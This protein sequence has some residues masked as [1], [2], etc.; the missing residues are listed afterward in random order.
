MGQTNILISKLTAILF[1]L[2]FNS[3][4]AQKTFTDS[5]GLNCSYAN[6]A[7][8]VYLTPI[9]IPANVATNASGNMSIKFKYAGDLD[10]YNEDLDLR[11]ENNT[12]IGQCDVAPNCGSTFS[13]KTFTLPISTFGS[14]INDNQLIFSATSEYGINNQCSFNGNSSINF[15]TEVVVSINYFE[16]A[17]DAGIAGFISPVSQITTGTSPIIISGTNFGT[18]A[19]NSVNVGW[20]VNGIN[21]TAKALTFSTP[22]SSGST[23][24]D[25]LANYNF[26]GATHF[27]LKSWTNSPNGNSDSLTLNDTT[28]QSTC[29]G[30]NGTYTVGVSGANYSSLT[31]AYD[32]LKNCGMNGPVTLSLISNITERVHLQDSI[33]GLTAS[34]KL[35]IQGSGYTLQYDGNSTNREVISLDGINHLV[36]DSLKIKTLD[37]YYGTGIW[38]HNQSDSNEVKNCY[39]DLTSTSYT[40][41]YYSSGILISGTNNGINN[42]YNGS[43]NLISSNTFDGGYYGMLLTGYNTIGLGNITNVIEGNK[44]ID[45]YRYGIYNRYSDLNVIRGNEFS[46]PTRS[47]NNY[48]GIYSNY[49]KGFEI[50]AN[51]FM[52][53]D[54]SSNTTDQYL[55]YNNNC[56]AT[57]ADPN[58][59]FNNVVYDVISGDVLYFIYDYY[60]QYQEVYNNTVFYKN[61]T[62]T[63]QAIYGI[64]NRYNYYTNYKNNNFYFDVETN[65]QVF[66]FY[67]YS[68]SS[69]ILSDNNNI[70]IKDATNKGNQYFGYASGYRK[71]LSDFQLYY[72]RETNGFES[73]PL[74]VS[75][76]TLIPQNVA[77]N[78]TGDSTVNITYDVLGVQRGN[79]PDVGAYEFT[80]TNYDLALTQINLP[81]SGC[82]LNVANISGTVENFGV[83]TYSSFTA[84]FK[85]G[86]AAVQTQIF[87]SAIAS[88]SSFN[89]TFDSLAYFPTAGQTYNV[90]V[91]ITA[92]NDTK[93]SN[94]SILNQQVKNISPILLSTNDSLF[95]PVSS[96]SYPIY[97]NFANGWIGNPNAA[98]G[99][100]WTTDNAFSQ[101]NTGP[102]YDHTYGNTSGRYFYTETYSYVDDQ[103]ATLTS[104][105]IELSDTSS[106]I[107]FLN[108]WYHKYGSTMG[109]LFIQIGNGDTFTTIDSIMGQTHTA[110]SN[111]GAPWLLKFIDLS[112]YA[113]Q[114]FNVRFKAVSDYGVYGDMALDD[115]KIIFQPLTCDSISTVTIS[116]ITDTSADLSWNNNNGSTNTQIQYGLTGFGIGSGTIDST[117]GSFY[118]ISGLSNL[119]NYEVYIRNKCSNGNFT[120]WSGPHAIFTNSYCKTNLHSTGCGTASG[121]NS[122]QLESIQNLNTGCTGITNDN[123]SFYPNQITDITEDESYTIT[124]T[125]GGTYRTYFGVWMDFNKDGLFNSTNEYIGSLY[126]SNSSVPNSYT[127]TVPSGIDTGITMMRVRSDYYNVSSNESCSNMTYGETEDYLVNLLPSPTCPKPKNLGAGFNSLTSSRLFWHAKGLGSQWEVEYGSSNFTFGTG[128]Q[129]TLT[130][131]TT[132]LNNLGAYS[133]YDYYVRSICGAADTSLWT[134]P[135]NFNTFPYCNGQQIFFGNCAT[136]PSYDIGHV[137]LNT[138]SSTTTN[139][140]FYSYGNFIS[141]STDLVPS[142][143]YQITLNT[144][145]ASPTYFGVWV[146]FN[147]DGD[148]D[149]TNEFA[150]NSTSSSTSIQSGLISVPLTAIQGN[151]LMRVRSSNNQIYSNYSCTNFSFG[152]TEDYTINILA[153]PSC[154]APYNLY[155]YGL[156]TSGASIAWSQQ[157]SGSKW[158]VQYDSVGFTLGTGNSDTTLN[159]NYTIGGLK[160]LSSYDV[161]V[162]EV[163]SSTDSSS[164]VGPFNFITNP[165]CTSN[166]NYS[167]CN[168]EIDTVKFGALN[169]YDQ[170]EPCP[171]NSYHTMFS[172]PSDLAK[173]S[174]FEL[175]VRIKSTSYASTGIWIDWNGDGDFT[176]TDEWIG[177]GVRTYGSL[178]STNI[179]IPI[180]A[181]SGKTLMRVRTRNGT[182]YNSYSCNNLGNGETMDFLLDI[183]EP[184]GCVPP[185]EL[186]A[187]FN[188]FTSSNIS[189]GNYSNAPLFEIEYDTT[190]YTFGTGTTLYSTDSTELISGLAQNG[191]YDYY[192]RAIC[193]TADTSAW[194]S[195]F[196]FTT[197]PYCSGNTTTL[198]YYN[199]SYQCYYKLKEFGIDTFYKDFSGSACPNYSYNL[200]SNVIQIEA[201]SNIPLTLGSS[202]AYTTGTNAAIGVWIDYNQDGDFEDANEFVGSATRYVAK[203]YSINI[204]IP[205][206]ANTGTTIMRVRTSNNTAIYNYMSCY[207]NVYGETKDFVIDVLPAPTCP[208][209]YNLTVN[210]FTTNAARIGFSSTGNGSAWEVKYG[211]TGFNPDSTGTST[212]WY[213]TNDSIKG[214]SSFTSYDVYVKEICSS[215]DS[216][217]W[218]NSVSF[219]TNPYCII[220]QHY[221]GCTSY[222]ID[223]VTYNGNS[224]GG[225]GCSGDAT[226]YSFYDR[227]AIDTLKAGNSHSLILYFSNQYKYTVAWID[228]NKN[229]VFDNTEYYYLVYQY[230]GNATLNFT[231]PEEFYGDLMIRL[232]TSTSYLNTNSACT[233]YNYG[234]SEDYLFAVDPID[235]PKL[236]NFTKSDITDSS[237]TISWSQIDSN[238]VYNFRIAEIGGSLDT[239]IYASNK[240]YTFSNLTSATAYYIWAQNNCSAIGDSLSKWTDSLQVTTLCSPFTAEYHENFNSYE[241]ING[242]HQPVCWTKDDHTASFNNNFY[243]GTD[244]LGVNNDNYYFAQRSNSSS[245]FNVYLISPKFSDFDYGKK[246]ISFFAKSG[247]N[248][249]TSIV[250]GTTNNDTISSGN[251]APLQQFITDGSYQKFTYILDNATS[252]DNRIAFRFIQD[253]N[254]IVYFDEFHYEAP[255][256]CTEPINLSA[257]QVA[258]SSA[259]LTWDTITSPNSFLVSYGIH[260]NS[261]PVGDSGTL[262][263]SSNLTSSLSNLNS[264]TTYW[265]MV[266]SICGSDS[267]AWGGPSYFTTTC[268]PQAAPVLYNFN[269]YPN[270]PTCWSFKGS[271]YYWTNDYYSTP[272]SGTGP[273]Y[274]G[275]NNYGPNYQYLYVENGLS[276]RGDSAVFIMQPVKLNSLTHPYFTFDYHAYG[277]NSGILEIFGTI[278]NGATW[279]KLGEYNKQYQSS[280]TRYFTEHAIDLMQFSGQTITLKFKATRV[281]NGVLGDIA[282]DQLNFKEAPSCRSPQNIRLVSNYKYNQA[283]VEWDTVQGVSSYRLNYT[284]L[285]FGTP[286]GTNSGTISTNNYNYTI[287]GVNQSRDF[288][289]QSVC[290][291]TYSTPEGPYRFTNTYVTY[292]TPYTQDFSTSYPT[293]WLFDSRS[294]SDW[295]YGTYSNGPTA[296]SGP[297]YLH[298]KDEELVEDS[299]LTAISPSLK[300]NNLTNPI[301]EFQLN[302]KNNHV[303]LKVFVEDKNGKHLAKSIRKTTGSNW[304]KQIIPLSSYGD[305]VRIFFVADERSEF[306]DNNL[307]IDLVKIKSSITNDLQT[308]SLYAASNGCGSTSGSFTFQVCNNGS[309]SQSNV[310]V[311]LKIGNTTYS[312]SVSLSAYNCSNVTF[313]NISITSLSGNVALKAYAGLSG[314]GNTGNDTTTSSFYIPNTPQN[315]VVLGD[316]ICNSGDVATLTVSGAA[317]YTWRRNGAFVSNNSTLNVSNLTGTRM[318]TVSGNNNTVSYCGPTNISA[319]LP[320]WTQN[321]G[322]VFDAY[323]DFILDSVE[324]YVRYSG[325]TLNFVLQNA[326][327]TTIST[328]SVTPTTSSGYEKFAVNI[329]VPKGNDLKIINTNNQVAN[330]TPNASQNQAYPFNDDAGVMQLK[331]YSNSSNYVGGIFNW[332]ISTQSCESKTDSVYAHFATIQAPTVS[333]GGT[334]CLNETIP[335]LTATGDS[336]STYWFLASDLNTPLEIGNLFNPASS[337]IGSN[338][339]KVQQKIGT[340]FSSYASATINVLVNPVASVNVDTSICKGQAVRLYAGGGSTYSWSNGSKLTSQLVAPQTTTTYS[341]VVNNTNNC[342]PDTAYVTVT[343]NDI[344]TITISGDQSVCIGDAGIIIANSSAAFTWNNSLGNNDTISVSPSGYT[345]YTAIAID[346]IGCSSS[347]TH[348]VTT[349]SLPNV[350]AG[351]SAFICNGDTTSLYATGASN[352]VWN[353]GDSSQSIEVTP[354]ANTLYTVNATDANGCSNSDTVSV[355]L[356]SN[357]AIASRNDTSVAPGTVIS[358]NPV[359]SGGSGNYSY[360]WTPDSLLA[361]ATTLNNTT[362]AL[363][364]SSVFSF[365]VDDLSNGC[366]AFDL[367]AINIVGGTL[368]GNPSSNINTICNGDSILLLAN[369]GGGTGT[370]TYNWSPGYLFNDSTL[371]NPVAYPTQN[372]VLDVAISDSQQTINEQISVVAKGLPFAN[373]GIDTA[374]CLGASVTLRATGGV[375][376][377]WGLYQYKDS[378]RV[379]PVYPTSYTVTV[380]ANNGCKKTDDVYVSIKSLPTASIIGLSKICIGD[381]TQLT[382]SGGI[383]YAWSSGGNQV[384]EKVSASAT[385]IFTVTATAVNGCSNSSTHTISL[386][387]LPKVDAGQ[388]VGICFGDSDTLTATGALNYSWSN[389]QNIQSIVVTP[390]ATEEYK[391]FGTDANGCTNI[392]SVMVIINQLPSVTAGSDT[393]ICI[394]DT[395]Q[396]SSSEGAYYFWSNGNQT[397]INTVSPTSTSDYIVTVVN[398]SGCYNYDTIQVVVN[399]LPTAYAGVDDTLCLNQ[400]LTL[401]ATGGTTYSWNSGSITAA[402]SVSPVADS[403]FVVTVTDANSCS[404]IDSVEIFINPLPSPSAGADEEICLGLSTTLSASGGTSY[405]WSNNISVKDNTVSNTTNTT[406]TVTVTDDNNCSASDQVLVSVNS[407]PIVVASNDTTVCN[408]TP[409]GIVASGASSYLWNNSDT[410][411]TLLVTPINTTNYIVTGTDSNS[412]ENIDTVKVWVNQNPFAVASNDTVMCIEDTITISASGATYYFW[413]NGGSAST[414]EVSPSSNAQYIVTVVDAHGCFNIDSVNVVVNALPQVFT[415]ANDTIC[416]NSSAFLAGNGATSYSWSNGGI[417][418]NTT[419]SPTAATTYYVVG[420]DNNSC[421][422]I[423]S[424][425]INLFQLPIAD[426]GVDTSVCA[427][428]NALLLATGGVT[429]YSWSSGYSSNSIAV[430]PTSTTNYIVTVTDQNGCQDTDSVLVEFMPLPNV[431][432]S[433]D[434]FTCWGSPVQV[435]VSGGATYVWSTNDITDSIT[436]GPSVNTYYNVVGTDTN[437][438]S[439][440]DSVLVSVNVL[441]AVSTSIDTSIC[442]G[443]TATLFAYGGDY[444]FWNNGGSSSINKVS[445]TATSD[446]IVTIVNTQGCYDYDTVTVVVNSNPIA[447][448]GVDTT[449]CW[450]ESA[451][452]TATGGNSYQWNT[453]NLNNQI[454]VSPDST[455]MYSII[456]TDANTC[457]DV[458]SVIV[459]VNSL[460]NVSAGVDQVICS[461][462]TANLNA[463]GNGLF[464]WSNNDSIAT[465]QLVVTDTTNYM[466]TLIDSNSCSSSDTLTVFT[467][468]LPSA[469]ASLDTSVCLGDSATISASGGTFYFWNNG[470][471]SSTIKVGPLNT[472][473]FIVTVVDTNN[474]FNVDTTTI[475][476]LQLPAA[477]AGVNDTI[478]IGT[479][480]TLTAIGGISYVWSTGAQTASIFSN[481]SVSESYSV[482]VTDANTCQNSDFVYV[483]VNTLPVVDAG[484]NDTIC[485]GNS[486]TLIG[487][488]ANTYQWSGGIFGAQQVV[489][490]TVSNKFS[491]MGTDIN[492]CVNYDSMMVYVNALPLANA[493]VDTFACNGYPVTLNATGGI[494]Y[495]WSNGIQTALN[496][497]SLM[498][499]TTYFVTVTD[500]NGCV[501]SDTI[502]VAINSLPTASGGL[503]QTVCQGDSATFTANGGLYYFWDNGNSGNPMK[504]VPSFTGTYMVTVVDNNGCFDTDSVNV[505][506]NQLPSVSLGTFSKTCDNSTLVTL[507]GGIPTGGTYSS[508]FVNNGQFNPTTSGTGS[509]NIFYAYTNAQGCTDSIGQ[510][511]TVAPAPT[512]TL[513]P[514]ND[515][516]INSG[517]LALGGGIP[518]GGIYSGSNVSAGMFHPNIAGVGITTITYSYTNA[519]GCSNSTS[520]DLNVNDVPHPD[521][522]KDTTVC[523]NIP[524]DL[525]PG[526]YT[527]YLWSTGATIPTIIANTAGNVAV[528]VTDANTCSNSDDI[529]IVVDKCPSVSEL[530]GEGF[531]ISYY[532]N[533]ASDLVN[534]EISGRDLKDVDIQITN[535]NGSVVYQNNISNINHGIAIPID[536]TGISQGVYFIRLQTQKGTRVDC[537]TVN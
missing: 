345:N 427:G 270:I 188:S 285:G 294:G 37:Y 12:Y 433:V 252:G 464:V 293:S 282:V 310:P 187:N 83:N 479:Q 100:F 461:N 407:L 263:T 508:P 197:F 425:T 456:V 486:T 526:T 489:S 435:Y 168:T 146:D 447:N 349:L 275:G 147:N 265:F 498:V 469:I 232:R 191:Y 500:L 326:Q 286:S 90:D 124:L 313:S 381:S 222:Y 532:P 514:F 509:F 55:I 280:Q 510:P 25:T 102:Y 60:G 511:I 23:F 61:T 426:A 121:I 1:S 373:A 8:T 164:W 516:C 376:Y 76:S 350:D 89:F 290:G 335:S 351:S 518:A 533:P 499:P 193:D 478:C 473:D 71:S 150:Y 5:T 66:G 86:S 308:S 504:V 346:S 389:N 448:A 257:T 7:A 69:N 242:S 296:Y 134:G 208:K 84:S 253:Y 283:V 531:E 363:T 64:Y 304:A 402:N 380:T 266:K 339:Y 463:T 189:W 186:G 432:T 21:Q 98:T 455:T 120:V 126:T 496:T 534:L 410:G 401:N 155:S 73:D 229:G 281:S 400:T 141:T 311:Y 54:F 246:Q 56:D 454:V 490:P 431:Q 256:A 357:L 27:E 220:N 442:F 301:L 151:T 139:C 97:G 378:L 409:T 148:F 329:A 104:P 361:S 368:T 101:S 159:T 15:C 207:T 48:Y 85:V 117:N 261:S 394:G 157:G 271:Q 170:N 272:T 497:V 53:M 32:D 423:D 396:L 517:S 44:F 14:W 347:A 466:V 136:S 374:T 137:G 42:N 195:S 103:V 122:V 169:Y 240:P 24:F 371:A 422:N 355:R 438:C 439:N 31:A 362:T 521:L 81:D 367:V 386:D 105:C 259:T 299:N 399:T 39:F 93:S 267:S 245:T 276:N 140:P 45:Q 515:L 190:G 343:V 233:Y 337:T 91:W 277:T 382:A 436:V 417:F 205:T 309:N 358:L 264:T 524:Y 177:T 244:S 36:L 115:I 239:V 484:S 243:V 414:Q 312:D 413:N 333:N 305:T 366:S 95:E 520:E 216:S 507:T 249:N 273:Y 94:D 235:C 404:S 485:Y 225:N 352:Y 204:N 488:G 477:N 26:S 165:Y 118:H 152:E 92:T 180:T 241:V 287:F 441:P 513:T 536:I 181:K 182:M 403:I 411:S 201:G 412:C 2:G 238:Q 418:P 75:D 452:L 525:S 406:Y 372:T 392:D 445:P 112:T 202:S 379:N 138:I 3:S 334:Y 365:Y 393:A 356:K 529:N 430:T 40:G 501:K 59:I 384:I 254:E 250:L 251:F 50:S 131:T 218:S 74:F 68:N 185:F 434:T 210:G 480:A 172:N 29:V 206:T 354:S 145:S 129:T 160:T 108:F 316:T 387:T 315:L 492:G 268:A 72:S 143:S 340:C 338:I 328:T 336:S 230:G 63:S 383:G 9:S 78:N 156:S 194:S 51:V 82:G 453:T 171:A 370:Y 114:S 223:S 135:F 487:T 278:N 303:G 300:I 199:T 502:N 398:A 377:K 16:Y 96:N 35:I 416:L 476:I 462:T 408:G 33:N 127:F 149:D 87:T 227:R 415:S 46:R 110:Y 183:K 318:Y 116:S 4:L 41:N 17:D 523:L 111:G 184:N 65:S 22:I 493:G 483:I 467:L 289:V 332:V 369:A 364:K 284:T 167:N 360:T 307:A 321:E 34:N 395:A 203:P 52:G 451:T 79:K 306:A 236:Q 119:T 260:N 107:P 43:Y 154:P 428:D 163:C 482:T 460:P 269:T 213:S 314:D 162:K 465:T 491:L 49:S 420:T 348:Y 247:G 424:V 323:Q 234:E 57:S 324:V 537:I 67:L 255:P 211:S 317:N 109:D 231:I 132:I 19:L 153:P 429:G 133:S 331:S 512:V 291:S 419:V 322:H 475:N 158:L 459:N 528:T 440:S 535:L 470:G 503:D 405:V 342:A 70:Y 30:M 161:Y 11:G 292:S 325:T 471:S 80:P 142:N 99:Y 130:D 505:T 38:M 219:V 330:M 248:Y 519:D 88:G 221:Y 458:D 449:I 176:D 341:V 106:Q 506:V 173:L 174:T 196:T 226:G 390:T 262:I 18:N 217:R 125:S 495:T 344:P 224:I 200:E 481:P 295:K 128:T 468:P 320:I 353:T 388:N 175:R 123:Y 297:S 214:L 237:I 443:D 450:L 522:G 288:Y 327:G 47:A 457:Y 391:V 446:Y 215:T 359:V 192:V 10:A 279:V 212:I 437:T 472:S 77:L 198:N 302:S 166:L 258:D 144:N 474:C 179:T 444:Y 113:G 298:I 228:W 274:D 421:S 397:A 58:R 319:S 178:F 494:S 385:T 28:Y 62:T 530:A 527:S 6:G 209:P 20:S 375:S 13:S